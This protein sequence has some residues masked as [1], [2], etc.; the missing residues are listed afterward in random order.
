[1]T[2]IVSA[3]GSH[4]KNQ[5]MGVLVKDPGLQQVFED[6]SDLLLAYLVTSGSWKLKQRAHSECQLREIFRIN[7][8]QKLWGTL[9]PPK[10]LGCTYHNTI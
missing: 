1:M 2:R 9:I 7:I 10:R 4:F 5:L 8:D 3:Q 6:M